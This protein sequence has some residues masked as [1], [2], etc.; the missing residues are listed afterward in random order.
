VLLL[1]DGFQHLQLH[2]DFDLVLID[3]LHP[4]GG[5]HLLPLGRLREPVEGLARADAFLLTRT[6]EAPNTLAIES[7]LRQYNLKA[8]VF[9]SRIE[10]RQWMGCDGKC[11]RPNG[12]KGIAAVAFCGLGNPETFWRSLQ[13]TGVEPLDKHT[14]EDHHRYTP[15]EIRRLA[16]HALDVGA[17]ALVTTAKDAVNLPQDFESII[18]PLKLYW[19]E[20]GLEIDGREELIAL[21]SRTVLPAKGS[22]V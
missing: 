19:L 17:V 11:L 5:G 13:R 12:L 7:V 8:P 18:E 1:D 14:Y 10:I 2:R 15:V 21:I 4:F 3:G 6:K 9:N 20:I 22:A 16:R